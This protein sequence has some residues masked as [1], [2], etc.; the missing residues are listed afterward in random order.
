MNASN[1]RT[2][3]W[4]L[5]FIFT[6]VAITNIVN[7][8]ALF[9]R[10]SLTEKP[11][12]QLNEIDL[13]SRM[14]IGNPLSVPTKEQSEEV[15]EQITALHK[16]FNTSLEGEAR[17]RLAILEYEFKQGDPMQTLRPLPNAK[18]SLSEEALKRNA[19]AWMKLYRKVPSKPEEIPEI[20]KEIRNTPLG[21]WAK[22]AEAH[23]YERAGDVTR[24]EQLRQEIR[25][26]STTLLLLLGGMICLLIL[27]GFV[28]LIVWIVVLLSKRWRSLPSRPFP[29]M[30][31]EILDGSL[32]GVNLFFMIALAIGLIGFKSN[33]P[34]LTE[35]TYLAITIGVFSYLYSWSRKTGISLQL[36]GLLPQKPFRELVSGML[37]YCAY[38]VPLV[39]LMIL[40]SF[41]WSALPDQTNPL[42]DK[43]LAELSLWEKISIFLQAAVFAP[44]IEEIVFRGLL[45][46]VLWQRTGRVWLSAFASGYLFAVIHPQFLS[47][48]LAITMLGMILALLYAYSRSL[49][50]CMLVHALNNGTITLFAFFYGSDMGF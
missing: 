48:L 38:L 19:N 34:L 12:E 6:F 11:A 46:S 15:K 29:E 35:L 28:G 43:A 42:T 23:A 22:L 41:L 36:L 5:I 44:F 25:A 1:T 45:F 9:G 21:W 32:W 14:L 17:R 3:W 8:I 33:M 39:P 31:P 2:A 40:L 20:I 10:T 26:E 13:R 37:A 50:P 30:H 4:V 16:L 49:L 7:F 47:G 18:D 27:C 24:G